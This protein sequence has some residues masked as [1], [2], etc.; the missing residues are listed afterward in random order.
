MTVRETQ[1]EGQGRTVANDASIL[2]LCDYKKRGPLRVVLQVEADIVIL[3]E[4]IK[5]RE[6]H[7]QEI[8]RLEESEGCHRADS[9][10]G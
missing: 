1:E 7:L 2:V 9:G 5:I 6:I 10:V 8:L 4:R 3:G